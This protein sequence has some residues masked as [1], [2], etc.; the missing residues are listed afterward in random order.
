MS[1][2]VHLRDAKIANLTLL[3]HW[4]EQPHVIASDPDDDW[5]WEIELT[6]THPWREQLIA[7]VDGVAIVSGI[8]YGE[9]EIAIIWE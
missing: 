6:K 1:K 5:E 8:S 9:L 2:N 4:E 7:E 3:K